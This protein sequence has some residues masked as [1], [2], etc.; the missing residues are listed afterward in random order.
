VGYGQ[1]RRSAGAGFLTGMLRRSTAFVAAVVISGMTV[2]S[3]Q[4]AAAAARAETVREAQWWLDA[5]HVPQA[6]SLAK[7]QGV[8]VAVIDTG[9]DAGHPDLNGAVLPGMS[10]SA[11]G[12]QAGR[13]DPDGH[14]THMAGVIA[15]RGGGTNNALGVAPAS[16]ILPIATASGSTMGSLADPVNYA[17]EHGAKIIN[18]SVGRPPGAESPPGEVDAIAD[19]VRK[20]VVVVISVGN[21]PEMNGPNTLTTI[22]GV[23]VVGGS[24]RAGTVSASSIAARQLALVA[25]ADQIVGPALRSKYTSGY[26]AATGT[27]ESTAMVSGVA[28]LIW[29]KFPD[30]D[31]NNVI[32]RLIASAVDA[33]PPG[34]DDTYGFGIVDAQRALT[35]DIPAVDSN[36]LGQPAAGAG[37]EPSG[38]GG[39]EPKTSG[40]PRAALFICGAVVLLVV[41]LLIGLVVW[42]ATRRRAPRA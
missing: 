2:L 37:N 34:R 32:N 21:K 1:R 25:P 28:A 26:S 6:Q 9:V 33:G 38:S 16:S 15:A 20:G 13:T 40:F 3:G 12:S 11:P 29:S 18:M 31:A 19:A 27:S 36:P 17:V 39:Y 8:T 5:I 7:G 23:V 22:P 10:F 35:M 4:T 14:G 42:L 41:A 30:L 24:S